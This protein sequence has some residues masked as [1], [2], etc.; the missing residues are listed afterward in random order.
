MTWFI[1]NGEDLP[2][3]QIYLSHSLAVQDIK[4]AYKRSLIGPFWNTLS[5]AIQVTTMAIVFSLIFKIKLEDY[6]PWLATS[7][8]VWNLFST[9]LSEGANSLIN[10][11]N[12]IRQIRISPTVYFLRS[13]EKSI[14]LFGHNIIILPVIYL[15]FFRNFD[16]HMLLA[17]PGLVLLIANLF[18]ITVILGFACA[19]Y[20]DLGPII[21]SSVNILYFVTPIMWKAENLGNGDL[22]HLLLGLNPVYHLFQ[23][24]R[25]PLVGELPTIENWIASA[26][27]FVVGSTA[28]F[29]VYKKNR[30][31]IA[32]WI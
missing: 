13:I 19:K 28:A 31:K 27:L 32:Y 30:K 25:Q 3:R 1:K 23:I 9:S 17:I 4:H 20:R 12:F 26:L 18:W 29:F 5:M 6:F 22:A 24:V 16:L 7:M 14:I 2:G 8:L 11:E 15:L 21:T 10:S